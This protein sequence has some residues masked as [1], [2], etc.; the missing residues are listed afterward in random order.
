MSG[1]NVAQATP[2]AILYPNHK[3]TPSETP[4]AE[5]KATTESKTVETKAETEESK[6]KETTTESKEEP[7]WEVKLPEGSP[8]K[9]TDLEESLAYA[10]QNGFSVEQAQKLVDRE[11]AVVSRVESAQRAHLEEMSK[12]WV[13]ESQADKEF[14]GEAFNTN[15][16][17]AKRVVERFGTDNFKKMLNDS[18][19]GNNPE[20]LRIFTRIGK[21]MAE[22]TLVIPGSQSASRKKSIEEIFYPDMKQ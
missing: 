22:D 3:E 21:T 14:G 12:T 16:E 2:E 17:L 20:V 9:A 19:F 10:K 13:K 1:E 6:T 8:L 7:K 11:S 18:G 15:V 5:A 4:A